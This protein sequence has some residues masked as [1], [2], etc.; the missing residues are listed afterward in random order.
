MKHRIHD[1]NDFGHVAVVL[2]GASAEREV[3]LDSG[4]A[5]LASLQQQRVKAFAIDGLSALIESIAAG[6]VTR[7]FNILHGA[8]GEDGVLQGLLKAHDIPFTGCNVLGAALTMDKIRSK[9]V[10]QQL[11][12]PTADFI[13]LQAEDNLNLKQQALIK[14]WLPVVV[15][16]NQQGSTVGISVVREINQL[17]QAVDAARL[18]DE[19]LIIERYIDG[20]D[21]TVAYVGEAVFPSI[22]IRPEHG[23]YD[24]QAK[25]QSDTTEYT[26]NTL[27]DDEEQKLRSLAL[28][29]AQAVGA[30]GWG[31]VD[32]MRDRQGQ[33]W[34]LEVNTVP[35]MTSHSLVPKAVEAAGYRYDELVWAIL[36][37]SMEG[38]AS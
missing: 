29:A 35:G 12:L 6:K 1:A 8:D 5:V 31:R 26:A 30:N 34:L 36:E 38:A 21:Y 27:A 19:T 24:Y 33:Y 37:T 16:P 22:R 20:D 2:G 28:N 17:N 10:W 4:A 25:Y 15:K 14:Q 3:S 32:F 23:F 18:F 11:N 9:Y 13:A 7:V